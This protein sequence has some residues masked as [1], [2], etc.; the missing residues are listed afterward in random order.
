[1]TENTQQTILIVDDNDSDRKL[2][3][4]TLMGEGYRTLE[5]IN[6]TDGLKI[7]EANLNEINLVLTD[8]LMP[9]MD[10]IEFVQHIRQLA[11]SI[12]VIFI[13]G[14]KRTSVLDEN[15]P[16]RV[17]F[18]QKSS[19]FSSLTTKVHEVLNGKCHLLNLLNK[20]VAIL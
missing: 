10:G 19:D 15:I 3:S 18:L 6:G 9:G 7:F 20:F 14:Y 2:M 8:I 13:S 5:A 16:F 4:L 12:K 1:M 17:D 11:P